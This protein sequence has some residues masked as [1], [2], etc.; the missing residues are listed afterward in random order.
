MKTYD[1]SKHSPLRHGEV[2]LLKLHPGSGSTDLECNLV[3]RSIGPSSQRPSESTGPE[4]TPNAPV[5]AGAPLEPFEA[6]SY[7]WGE[8]KDGL[9]VK[10]LAE[11]EA[12]AI[13][14][15]PNLESAL[16]QLRSPKEY[17]FFWVD[18]LCINQEDEDEKSSQ[19][20][21]TSDI[22]N[23]ATNVCVWLGVE[24]ED[25]AKAMNFIRRCLNLDDFDQLVRDSLAS[26]E[27][28]ALFALMRRPW[29][30]RRWIIQE[31][32]LARNATLHCGKDQVDWR[33]FADVTSLFASRQHDIRQLFRE[34][35]AFR[36][37][38]DYLGDLNEL[39]AV[40]LVYASDNLVRKWEDGRI[41]E[42][43]LS[44]EALMSSLSAF[45]AS[46]PHDIVYAILWLANDAR[47]GSKNAFT[48]TVNVPDLSPVTLSV[49]APPSP[50]W[51]FDNRPRLHTSGAS[52]RSVGS[53]S[54]SKR[55][56]TDAHP[57][58]SPSKK[59]VGLDILTKSQY[60]VPNIQITDKDQTATRAASE[61]QSTAPTA[62]S[63]GAEQTSIPAV[64]AEYGSDAGMETSRTIDKDEA[65]RNLGVVSYQ[66]RSSTTSMSSINSRVMDEKD[67]TKMRTYNAV[68]RLL[69]GIKSRSI[70]IDYKKTVFEVYKD[71]LAFT[72]TRSHS[73]DIICQ[74]WAPDGPDLPSWI[75]RLSGTAFGLGVNRVYRRINADPLVGKP[76]TDGL[77]YKAAKNHPA[78]WKEGAEKSVIV[79][80][81]VLDT[82]K[83][84]K[85]TATAGIIPSEWRDAVQWTNVDC[86]P[87][88][89]FW[90]TLIGNRDTHGRIPP[91]H[92][93][94]A[95]RAT[96]RRGPARG[97]LNT[98][99][100]IM[101]DCPLTI[102]DFLERVRCVVWSRRLVL[103][104]QLPQR[105]FLGLA[106]S[107]VKK[108]DKVC[109]L[110]GC[111]VPVIL[112]KF[113]NGQPASKQQKSECRHGRCSNEQCPIGGAQKDQEDDD[114]P[115]SAEVYYEFV[116]ECYVHGMMDGEA[117]GRKFREQEFEL[118]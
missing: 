17:K 25:S 11:G 20:Q 113:V 14:I 83:E 12:Y 89:H 61:G 85:E 110:F 44:L 59:L 94:A 90:R 102:R 75:P 53:A 92:W 56:S 107:K 13:S 111:S 98:G 3:C 100:L 109:I 49:A 34:S 64:A 81:F 84:K 62:Y 50:V 51:A 108:G 101:Y 23:N 36:N 82:I 78:Y 105:N 40:R 52:T 95:C 27:W 28:A 35:T 76:V 66:N 96:F 47:P 65:A 118:R 22:Y 91:S 106:P 60:T 42:R 77:R 2:R 10:I 99:E 43:L 1:H 39:G 4:K 8:K 6:L 18:A 19:I 41:M 38:P 71:L 5:F 104:D 97:D 93:K 45:E 15:R 63:H 37:P 16:R 69:D 116:G 80:G 33:E 67:E 29:F 112:R 7:T 88:D 68:S 103:F 54:H 72:I 21:R 74:P 57:E 114:H 117:F 79:K 46:D 48:M 87:P 30:S 26:K 31:I 24:E 115:D 86:Y 32:A 73:L 70:I 58:E 9:F 55:P